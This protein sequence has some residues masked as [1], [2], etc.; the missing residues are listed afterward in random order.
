MTLQFLYGLRIKRLEHDILRALDDCDPD[1]I[2]D[3]RVSIRRMLML[4]SVLKES[5]KAPYSKKELRI[6]KKKFSRAGALRDIQVQLQLLNLWEDKLSLRFDAYRNHLER[7][8][9]T[10]QQYFTTAFLTINLKKTI[11][12]IVS[13]ITYCRAIEKELRSLDDDFRFALQGAGALHELRIITKKLK[14]MLEIQQS[15]YPGFGST[16]T[17]RKHL[18]KIQDLLGAWHDI[19]MGLQHVNYFVKRHRTKIEDH[20]LYDNLIAF[21]QREKETVLLEIRS[22][23]QKQIPI[24]EL[25]SVVLS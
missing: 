8:A 13:R 10:L 9:K 16:E 3:V 14:Y 24:K 5:G 23:L 7:R 21:M 15:C 1:A 18:A 12:D 19:E 22:E 4:C 25:L 11:P 17:F 20:A 2:H 6:L